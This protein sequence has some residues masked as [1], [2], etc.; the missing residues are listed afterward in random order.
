MEEDAISVKKEQQQYGLKI[1]DHFGK[2]GRKYVAISSQIF[3]NDLRAKYD[4]LVS[5]EKDK[6]FELQ[7]YKRQHLSLLIHLSLG[8]SFE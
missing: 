2:R 7:E 1:R 8:L 5:F 3:S 4:M 6:H